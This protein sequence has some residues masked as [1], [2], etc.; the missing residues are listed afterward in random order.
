MGRVGRAAVRAASMIGR[1]HGR[2]GAGGDHLV[3]LIV[4]AGA[5]GRIDLE[6]VFGD[7]E[8]MRDNPVLGGGMRRWTDADRVVSGVQG[9]QQKPEGPD[10]TRG[11][12][13]RRTVT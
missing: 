7:G 8:L 2:D 1:C 13:C 9:V 10:V 4:K 5:A 3:D 12:E 11:H 6:Q